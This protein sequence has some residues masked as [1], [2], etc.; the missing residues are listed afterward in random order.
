MQSHTSAL[1]LLADPA[2]AAA[3]LWLAQSD[4]DCEE[5]AILLGKTQSDDQ[6]HHVQTVLQ[7]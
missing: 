6:Q 2:K 3:A 4:M 5:T 1:E 7:I